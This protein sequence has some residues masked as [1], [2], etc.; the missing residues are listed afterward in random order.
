[1]ILV[2][3]AD[4]THGASLRQMLGSVRRFEPNMRTIVYDL[5]LTV[6]QR[7]RIKIAFPNVEMRR[8]PLEQYPAHFDIKVRAGEYA[9]NPSSCG[10]CL[11]RRKSLSAGWTPA[12]F[13]SN[14]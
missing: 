9:W 1:M 12:M 4:W 3:G 11:K 6:G 10:A 14:R 8:F 5:G 2:T 13:W 7:L